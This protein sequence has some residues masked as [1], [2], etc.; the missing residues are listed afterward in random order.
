MVFQSPTLMP[1]ARI[2]ANV[3][4]PLDLSGVPRGEASGAVASALALV[5]LAE[6]A[7]TSRE[8]SGACRCA[9][10]SPARW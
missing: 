5:G 3:R 8:L 7:R 10:R 1:W 6:A 2:D 4:L 9:R